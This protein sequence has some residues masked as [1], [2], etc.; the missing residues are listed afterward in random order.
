MEIQTQL[1]KSL[2]SIK[3]DLWQNRWQGLSK[4]GEQY[5]LT[6]SIRSAERAN[7]KNFTAKMNSERRYWRYNNTS[8]PEHRELVEQH[9]KLLGKHTR[10]SKVVEF[11]Y[12]RG[13]ANASMANMSAIWHLDIA[14]LWLET[15]CYQFELQDDIISENQTNIKM[16]SKGKDWQNNVV[17]SCIL[18]GPSAIQQAQGKTLW[19]VLKED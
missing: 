13:N 18:Y 12:G 2:Y 16:K 1:P 17:G 9:V 3:C 11:G 5:K 14:Y 15:Q 6:F 7:Y 19:D 4:S 8:S 10:V